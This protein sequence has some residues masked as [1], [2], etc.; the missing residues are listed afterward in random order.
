MQIVLLCS[1][2]LQHWSQIV[3]ATAATWWPQRWAGGTWESGIAQGWSPSS[4]SSSA[5]SLPSSPPFPHSPHQCPAVWLGL[6]DRSFIHVWKGICTPALQYVRC[7]WQDMCAHK[8]VHLYHFR[9]QVLFIMRHVWMSQ[10]GCVYICLYLH[11]YYH[12]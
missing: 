7:F 10:H 6:E 11:M 2:D 1:F 12:E 4:P 8:M 9:L 3:A 5:G